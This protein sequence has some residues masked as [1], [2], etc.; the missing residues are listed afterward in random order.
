MARTTIVLDINSLIAAVEAQPE[1]KQ[2]QT[3]WD[4]LAENNTVTMQD[5]VYIVPSARWSNTTYQTKSNGYCTCEARK[6]CW[7]VVYA[8]IADLARENVAIDAAARRDAQIGSLNWSINPAAISRSQKQAYRDA[9]RA[10]AY[11]DVAEL[12]T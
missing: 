1:S 4:L 10:R 8:R 9:A 11:A 7:H 2:R 5:G 12:W 6:E 3:A